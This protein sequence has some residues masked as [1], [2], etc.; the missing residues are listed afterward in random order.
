VTGLG[1]RAY[2]GG[3]IGSVSYDDLSGSTTSLGAWVGYQLPMGTSGRS[4]LCPFFTGGLGLGPND[5]EGSGID[6]STRGFSA[7]VSWGMRAVQSNDFSLFPTIG[8][9]IAF[10]SF[11]LTDGVDSIEE[12]DTYVQL[13]FGLGL[14]LG[15]Q[16]TVRPSVT[17]PL[18]LEGADPVFSVQ[19]SLSLGAGR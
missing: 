2:G 5:I 3:S 13:G 4:Q 8:A 19:I 16:F 14:V 15:R 12:S 7:G 11:K 18:G 17:I 9:G 1:E 6:A 10:S